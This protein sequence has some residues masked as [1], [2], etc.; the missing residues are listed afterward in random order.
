MTENEVPE[1]PVS[2]DGEFTGPIP[3]PY[4][5]ISLGAV[6]YDPEGNEALQVQGQYARAAGCQPRSDDDG[7]VGRTPGRLESLD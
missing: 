2:V 6:A 4:S 1:I 7:V 3:G 5:M